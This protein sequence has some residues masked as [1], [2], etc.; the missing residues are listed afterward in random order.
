MH[1]MRKLFALMMVSLL[2]LTLAIAAVGCGQK[3]AEEAPATTETTPAT[4]TMPT[5]TT[6]GTMDTTMQA[7]TAAAH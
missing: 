7:D 2:A 4:E 3:A 6:M 5:D 1:K